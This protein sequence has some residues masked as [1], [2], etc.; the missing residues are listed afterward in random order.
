MLLP[1]TNPHWL[2]YPPTINLLDG[3][4]S[5][6]L[7]ASFTRSARGPSP[8]SEGDNL[9]DQSPTPSGSQ[10]DCCDECRLVSRPL[11]SRSPTG[12][13]SR[14]SNRHPPPH[15]GISLGSRGRRV[16]D[17]LEPAIISRI[18]S[19]QGLKNPKH[20]RTSKRHK[21]PM[22]PKSG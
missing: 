20:G 17:R 11:R 12:R 3:T 21:V 16:R 7:S 14:L 1:T 5:Q 8:G 9:P 19:Y 4:T 13:H 10:A 6:G 22:D 2:L 15:K 18:R